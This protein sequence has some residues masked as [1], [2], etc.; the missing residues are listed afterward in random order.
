MKLLVSCLKVNYAPPTQTTLQFYSSPFYIKP[1]NQ[2]LG[3]VTFYPVAKIALEI[4]VSDPLHLNRGGSG[5]FATSIYQKTHQDSKCQSGKSNRE[6]NFQR[7]K[8]SNFITR[9][10]RGK[11]PFSPTILK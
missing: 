4:R 10:N 2:G 5:S 3:S 6:T 1:F 7:G 8:M 9:K 11:F